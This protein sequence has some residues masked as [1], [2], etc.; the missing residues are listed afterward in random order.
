M[1][2]EE[3]KSAVYENDTPYDVL[4]KMVDI[5]N[6]HTEIF[7]L[8]HSEITEQDKIT[9]ELVKQNQMLLKNIQV[10]SNHIKLINQRL[11]HLEGKANE[12]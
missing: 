6:E 9:A 2:R 8:V 5:V 1:V 12:N 11:A 7:D 10:L 3:S 4:M